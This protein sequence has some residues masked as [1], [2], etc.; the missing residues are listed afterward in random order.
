MRLRAA[1][2]RRRRRVGNVEPST[3]Q[4]GGV[5]EGKGRDSNLGEYLDRFTRS[6]EKS[7]RFGIVR[8]SRIS[9]SSMRRQGIAI[10]EAFNFLI[11][12]SATE[13]QSFH[14]FFQ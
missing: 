8:I 2:V 10:A 9:L 11:V 1:L 5:E 13:T 6:C 3:E 7:A 12:L 4:M 14:P